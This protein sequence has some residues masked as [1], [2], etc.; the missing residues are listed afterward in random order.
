[1]RSNYNEV[2]LSP[3]II[4]AMRLGIWGAKFDT[5]Q[6]QSFIEGCLDLGM[7]TFDHADIYGGYTT[8]EEFGKVFQQQPNLRSQ[9]QL[10]TKCGIRFMSDNRPDNRI[11]SY[12]SSTAYIRTSVE[13][14]LRYLHSDYIDV[15]L[16]HRPDYLMRPDE[17]AEVIQELHQAGKVRAFGVSNFTPS[18]FD[19]LNDKIPLVTNQIEISLTK[20]GAFQDGTLEQCLRHGIRPMAWSPFEGGKL[21][22]N[23][24]IQ[25]VATPLQVKYDLTLDQLLLA[26]LMTHP[27]G[28]LPVLGTS[29][30]ERVTTATKAVGVQ[31]EREDW[32]DL[33]QASTGQ[34]VA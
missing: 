9:M 2:E 29:K 28:I 26:W 33:W 7:N 13:N 23:N 4:G 11:K 25:E 21:L 14:S 10:I 30:L 18:Q 17:V 1:M 20:L 22:Q 6:Y 5:S 19:L 31:L 24:R 32:Y 16:I 3:L 15:L 27:S 12:D 8:E 34:E